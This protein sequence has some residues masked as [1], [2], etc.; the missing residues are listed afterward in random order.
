MSLISGPVWAV[1]RIILGRCSQSPTE[2]FVFLVRNEKFADISEFD[3]L[4]REDRHGEEYGCREVGREREADASLTWL[5]SGRVYKWEHL[6][7]PKNRIVV[8]FNLRTLRLT[9]LLGEVVKFNERRGDRIQIVR[10]LCGFI[11]LVQLSLF[12]FYV[13]VTIFEALTRPQALCR[14]HIC[15]TS[16]PFN[17]LTRR[18]A[19]LL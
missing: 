7:Q 17:G 18:G 6:L 14:N 12:L 1:R 2:V 16:L 8:L 5:N 4:Q 13:Q 15:G 10:F 19:L 11:L 9:V 3:A